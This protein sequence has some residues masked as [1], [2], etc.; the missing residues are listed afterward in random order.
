MT[1]ARER[2]QFQRIVLSAQLERARAIVARYAEGQRFYLDQ[3]EEHQ[4]RI[5]RLDERLER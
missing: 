4:Y 2:D 3:I 1:T 5:G